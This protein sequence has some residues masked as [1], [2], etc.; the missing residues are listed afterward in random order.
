MSGS[1]SADEAWNYTIWE[2]EETLKMTQ[3]QLS[4]LRDKPIRVMTEAG[5]IT[6]TKRTVQR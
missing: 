2:L 1:T 4:G 3:A 5:S 6:R